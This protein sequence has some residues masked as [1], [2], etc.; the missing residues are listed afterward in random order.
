MSNKKNITIYQ[1]IRKVWQEGDE[2]KLKNFL[3]DN[4]LDFPQDIQEEIIFAFFEEALVKSLKE[5]EN[6]I[7]FQERVAKV[8]DSI[9][10]AKKE[11]S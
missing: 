9:K 10:K 1:K 3:I 2:E 7:K 11:I 5:V 4:L 8:L 6:K